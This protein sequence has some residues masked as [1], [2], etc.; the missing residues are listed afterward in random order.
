MVA[1]DE[2]VKPAAFAS[3]PP[4][5]AASKTAASITVFPDPVGD[6]NTML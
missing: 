5:V 6:E 4:V 3:S 2:A 1:S